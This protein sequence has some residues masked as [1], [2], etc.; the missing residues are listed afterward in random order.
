MNISLHFH[1]LL[2]ARGQFSKSF[3]CSLVLSAREPDFY[4]LSRLIKT[5][6]AFASG[7][8][9]SFSTSPSFD[10]TLPRQVK[11]STH[12]NMVTN[13]EV[14]KLT[15]QRR[16]QDTVGERGD[17]DFRDTSSGWHQNAQLTV[18]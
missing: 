3:N 9:T 16:L 11:W 15:G 6:A 14:R 13:T 18:Q 4:T 8:F 17:S 1:W 12:S 5:V 7:V 10:M 2:T